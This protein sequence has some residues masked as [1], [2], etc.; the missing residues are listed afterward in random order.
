VT[1][2]WR[3]YDDPVVQ[4]GRALATRIEHGVIDIDRQLAVV[5][6]AAES[7]STITAHLVSLELR[8]Q[9]EKREAEANMRKASAAR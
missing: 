4:A 3:V 1:C 6:D 8:R 2:P 7:M 9:A 5:V